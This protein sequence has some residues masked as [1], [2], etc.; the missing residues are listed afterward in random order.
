[1]T[2]SAGVLLSHLGGEVNI[3][4]QVELPTLLEGQVGLLT[5]RDLLP[6]LQELNGDVRGVKATD[7][8]DQCVF[9]PILSRVAAVHLHFGVS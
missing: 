6:V 3:L 1:M 9:F 7:V 5:V 4:G 2:D 8:A